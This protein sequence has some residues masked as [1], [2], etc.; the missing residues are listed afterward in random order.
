MPK[1]HQGCC[2]KFRLFSKGAPLNHTACRKD[3]PGG[4]VSGSKLNVL[5]GQDPDDSNFMDPDNQ[6]F[7][8][9]RIM[10]KAS[11]IKP[12]DPRLRRKAKPP[13]KAGASRR[14]RR[15]ELLNPE[16]EILD[17]G[18]INKIKET[19][20]LC[21]GRYIFADDEEDE[22]DEEEKEGGVKTR[23]KDRKYER[24]LDG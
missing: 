23:G 7:V 15:V 12:S 13:Q 16:R 22:E 14:S 1:K 3:R 5:L 17:A 4:E 10:S 24:V 19:R 9:A 8:C 6:H 21:G 11:E 2:N 20:I 18:S